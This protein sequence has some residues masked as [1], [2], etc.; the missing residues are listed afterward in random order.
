MPNNS[1]QYRDLVS[2]NLEVII[3]RMNEVLQ[4]KNLAD[5]SRIL[6]RID[7]TGE[8]PDWY[9]TLKNNHGLPFS[10]G[11][12]IGSVL[13]K[14]L[15]CVIEKYIIQAI[16]QVPNIQLSVNPARGVDIPEL[17]LGIKS[18]SENMCTSEPYFS[19]YERLLGN[20]YD[21]IVMLTDLQDKKKSKDRVTQLQLLKICYLTGTQ[22]A[23][24]N[25]CLTAK[26]CRNKFLN[27]SPSL[28]K[29]VR[30]LA[31]I[32]QSDWEGCRILELINKVLVGKQSFNDEF[33]KI[34]AK[35]NTANKKYKREN[36]P[37]LDNSILKRIENI[38]NV[39]PLSLGIINAADN[40]VV[41]N[42]KDNG[43]L[44][45]DNEWRRF[46]N[47][48]LDGKITMSF[49]LQWRYNFGGVF[50]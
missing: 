33:A 43:R 28:K 16:E 21:A 29:I 38:G 7:V 27:D 44:P 40:W 10:D 47:S 2:A 35:F 34:T 25:L 31:Y 46:M 19:A 17:E 30:F 14:L 5:I 41:E 32:N 20:E 42:Q 50:R 3:H 9:T 6:K 23:D 18:P 49:A 12:T 26:K 36:K 37:Q 45:N 39:Q 13:E 1:Q 4:G 48:P 24:E 8:L 11:K 15:V 22:I